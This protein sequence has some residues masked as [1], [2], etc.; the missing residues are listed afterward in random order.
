MP[1]RIEAAASARRRGVLGRASSVGLAVRAGRMCLRRAGRRADEID[2]LIHAGVYADG[3][4][5]EPAQAAFIQRRLGIHPAPGPRGSRGTLSFDLANGGCGFLNAVQ[6]L[7]ALLGSGDMALGM[8]VASDRDVATRG[9]EGFA[10]HD[11]G[12]AVLLR[13]GRED[14]GFGDFFVESFPEYADDFAS[15]AVWREGARRSF[16]GGRRPGYA[17]SFPCKPEYP[18]HAAACAERCVPAFLEAVGAGLDHVDLVLPSQHP[19]GFPRLLAEALGIPR[20]RCVE[21]PERG[22]P[23]HTAG[24]IA[25]LEAALESGAF[26]RARNVL[27]VT[28]GAGLTVSLAWYRH[29]PAERAAPRR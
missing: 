2:V 14:E 9:A 1:A 28:V 8:I 6:A 3:Q 26:A 20:E 4:I 23:A 17:W 24:P 18:R 21:V 11:A 15:E 29:R 7:E 13:P 27:F 10:F 25:A 5:A 22:A 12:G 16:L 19:A